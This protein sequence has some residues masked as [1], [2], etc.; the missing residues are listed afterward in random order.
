MEKKIP[1]SFITQPAQEF[2]M[3]NLSADNACINCTYLPINLFS[4]NFC[5]ISKAFLPCIIAKAVFF[6][7]FI[8][9][10]R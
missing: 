5:R 7:L 8:Y 1:H 9:Y 10:D 3:S 6:I 4:K 2:K